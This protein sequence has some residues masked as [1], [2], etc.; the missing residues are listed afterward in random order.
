MIVPSCIVQMVLN[1]QAVGV[2]LCIILANRRCRSEYPRRSLREAFTVQARVN[3]YQ[4]WF[5]NQPNI[6]VWITSH[7][8]LLSAIPAP[9]WTP[10][11]VQS[12]PNFHL[13]RRVILTDE[14]LLCMYD[15]RYTSLGR[16]AEKMNYHP[17]GSITRRDLPPSAVSLFL[18]RTSI[19]RL[20]SC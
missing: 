9:L 13:H 16:I 7:L 20:P 15:L 14:D 3:L 18:I 8:R 11:H 2:A 19:Y 12:L 17:V 4:G 5:T 1:A 6:S 10:C